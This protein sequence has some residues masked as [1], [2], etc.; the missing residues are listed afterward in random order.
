LQILNG[1]RLK[2]LIISKNY[3]ATFAIVACCT[4]LSFLSKDFLTEGDVA[5]I[6]L[7]GVVAVS[8]RFSW[9]HSITAVFLSVALTNFLFVPPFYTFHVEN[10]RSVI[11]FI[12]M[13]IVGT[14]VTW[15]SVSLRKHNEEMKIKEAEKNPFYAAERGKQNKI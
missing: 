1:N 7:L 14:V 11:T 13:F 6:Y 9:I 10:I 15:L 4:L 2:I 5:M 3:L 8:S 12:V